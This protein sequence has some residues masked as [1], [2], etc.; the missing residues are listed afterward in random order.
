MD[1]RSSLP[2]TYPQ[3]WSASNGPSTYQPFPTPLQ[4]STDAELAAMLSP[5]SLSSK[6]IIEQ[7]LDSNLLYKRRTS[8]QSHYSSSS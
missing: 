1:R 4:Q 8:L 6:P 3:L 2:S 5:L 7:Q